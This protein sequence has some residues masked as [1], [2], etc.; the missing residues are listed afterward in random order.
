MSLKQVDLSELVRIIQSNGNKQSYSLFNVKEKNTK[1]RRLARKFAFEKNRDEPAWALEICGDSENSNSYAAQ[2]SLLRRELLGLVFHLDISSGTERRKAMYKIRK[3]IFLMKVLLLFG[4]RQ[5]AMT[6]ISPAMKIAKEFELTSDRVELLEALS[7]HAALNGWRLKFERYDRELHEAMRL[8]MVEAEITSLDRQIDVESVGHTRPSI[9]A[10]KLAKSAPHD[11]QILFRDN[12]TFNVGLA[13]Y[14]IAVSSAQ[15]TSNFKLGLELC[16]KAQ[17]FLSRFPKLFTD[18]SKGEFELNRLWMALASRL[19]DVGA[20]AALECQK[21]FREGTNNW[22]IAKEYEFLLLMHTKQ[23]PEAIQLYRN[24]ATHNRFYM[25]PEHVRQKWELFGHYSTLTSKIG[26]EQDPTSMST[27][28]R[29]IAHK[30]PRYQEDS[31]D[32]NSSLHILQYLIL[33]VHKDQKTL[34][35]KSEGMAKYISRNFRERRNGQLYAFM[36]TLQILTKTDFDVEH[37]KIRAKQYIEQF[38]SASRERVDETQTLPFDL[39]W[40]WITNSIGSI[41]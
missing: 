9:R 13:Y 27:A 35:E 2:R 25:Q 28:F 41:E 26:K 8:R 39:M 19:Y 37:T 14:R 6:L 23:W 30:I 24:V 33:A 16:H 38:K 18:T 1:V 40:D 29:K 32:Y 10:Q 4:A 20:A 5:T 7:S 3:S 31:A 17:T 12:P 36:M 34:S 15:T 11:A 22:F 21:L